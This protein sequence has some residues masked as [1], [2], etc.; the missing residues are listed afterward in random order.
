MREVQK[1]AGENAAEQW[2]DDW[3]GCVAPIGTALAG[4]WQQR[5]RDPRAQIARRVDSV[6]GRSTE[7]EANAP[8]ETADQPGTEARSRTGCGDS[9]G[10]DR[11]GNNHEH[12]GADHFTGKVGEGAA[13]C[14]IGAEDA[15]L[16]GLV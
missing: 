5:M 8:H 11:A 2:P 12:H 14:G 1:Q 15:E 9:V 7:R 10:E 6:A 3:D 13:Y 16:R 4:D